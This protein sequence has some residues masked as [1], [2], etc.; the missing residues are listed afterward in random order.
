M[1]ITATRL[2]FVRT[3]TGFIA[4]C[5]DT[6]QHVFNTHGLILLSLK[7]LTTAQLMTSLPTFTVSYAYLQM[8]TQF[9]DMNSAA[10]N[11][12]LKSDLDA[13]TTWSIGDGKWNLMLLSVRPFRCLLKAYHSR[14]M[15]CLQKLLSYTITY[16]CVCT[17][18]Y[19][20]RVTLIPFVL[21]LIFLRSFCIEILDV[22]LVN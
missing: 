14:H 1:N 3:N 19:L 5:K 12:I 22:A 21:K 8:T 4:M 9:T 16:K 17:T 18:E 13:L 10:D 2:V 7:E 20:G 6:R 15:A 11:Q